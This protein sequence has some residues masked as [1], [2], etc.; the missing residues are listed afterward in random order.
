[1]IAQRIPAGAPS[2]LER[3]AEALRSGAIV[4]IPTETVYGLAALP[5]EAALER[6][7]MIKRRSTEKGIQLLVA[8]LEQAR[9]VAELPATAERLAAAFWPGPLTLVLPQR[10]D[11]ALS[12]LLTGGRPGVGVR[13]PDHAVPRALA[14]LLGPLAASSANVSGEPPA[15]TA[16][17]V[18]AALGDD[19]PLVLDDGPVRGGVSSTVVACAAGEQEP[20]ILREGALSR[21]QILAAAG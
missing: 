10:P 5:T 16:D 15:T 20:L 13:L 7:V 4:A 14:G 17:Q 9:Q 1:M 11:V 6:L 21:D 19:I 3:A 2:A 8:S 18:L 12:E